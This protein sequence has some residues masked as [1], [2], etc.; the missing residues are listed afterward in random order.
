VARND[1]NRDID[2]LVERL[3]VINTRAIDLLLR[4]CSC[5]AAPTSGPSPGT[6]RPV[7]HRGRGHRDASPLAERR[8]LSIETSGDVTPPSARMRSCCR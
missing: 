2:E 3:H 4:H 7:P 1:P 8:G 6:R 5:S